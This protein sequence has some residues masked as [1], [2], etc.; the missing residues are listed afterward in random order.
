MGCGYLRTEE[1]ISFLELHVVQKALVAF[2]AH[3]QNRNVQIVTDNTTV[4]FYLNKQEDTAPH[5]WHTLTLRYGIGVLGGALPSLL[6]IN[7]TADALR[8]IKGT[9]KWELDPAIIIELFQARNTDSVNLFTTLS[10]TDLCRVVKSCMLLTFVQHYQLNVHTRQDC[11]FNRPPLMPTS[12]SSNR[13]GGEMVKHLEVRISDLTEKLKDVSKMAFRTVILKK[14]NMD[15]LDQDGTT[16]IVIPNREV[17]RLL[18]HFSCNYGETCAGT[19]SRSGGIHR[20]NAVVQVSGGNLYEQSSKQTNSDL[21]PDEVKKKT[22]RN[23]LPVNCIIDVDGVATEDG[24]V[25]SC[26]ESEENLSFEGYVSE[27]KSC[28][29]R[30]RTGVYGTSDLPFLIALKSEKKKDDEKQCKATF[31]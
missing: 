9:N 22:F 30:M 16:H 28:Q 31:V 19:G 14:A 4:V 11:S 2:Q 5:Y 12:I 7:P 13:E 23:E 15:L 25:S 24:L 29:G 8:R 6:F 3:L 17:K 26:N 21:N 1:H 10:M 27:L 20:Q 18:I